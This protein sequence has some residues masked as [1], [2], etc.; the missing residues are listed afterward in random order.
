MLKLRNSAIFVSE[1]NASVFPIH[2]MS[3]GI[4]CSMKQSRDPID[5]L[6]YLQHTPINIVF[7]G[8]IS[9]LD[10]GKERVRHGKSYLRRCI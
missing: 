2:I 6:F 7:I 5:W 9:I 8:T 3:P 1:Y 10:Q 4:L